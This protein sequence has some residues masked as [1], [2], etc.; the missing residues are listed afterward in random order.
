MAR[1]SNATDGNYLTSTT[2]VALAGSAGPFTLAFWFRSASTSQTN[3]YVLGA[4][5]AVGD[6]A[7]IYEYTGDT[8]EFYASNYSGS[9]PRTDA[10]F[11]LA[12]TVWH[13]YCWRKAASGSSAWDK[14]MD[15]VKTQISAGIS[16]TLPALSGGRT[17]LFCYSAGTPSATVS[18]SLADVA[19]WGVS[20]S[21]ADVFWLS[22]G[23]RPTQLGHRPTYY[24]PL[25][26]AGGNEWDRVNGGQ[27][28]LAMQGVVTSSADPIALRPVLVP[29]PRRR[30]TREEE[31][32]AAGDAVPQVWSQYRRR[33]G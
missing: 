24:W 20:L 1:T 33:R 19:F 8:I 16:F 11:T 7:V 12:D 29:V 6:W 25:D 3:K 32:A 26:A 4:A 9:D 30:R 17:N 27:N 22:R 18:G 14:F 15:G 2:Q 21:D 31:E 5:A 13:H 10:G 28:K 23:K